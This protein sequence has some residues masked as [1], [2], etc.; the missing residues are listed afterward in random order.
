MESVF[1]YNGREVIVKNGKYYTTGKDG[2][3]RIFKN[4]EYLKNYLDD[5]DGMLLMAKWQAMDC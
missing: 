3:P 1:V 5:E 2:K 4:I